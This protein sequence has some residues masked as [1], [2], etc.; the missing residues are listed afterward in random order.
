MAGVL[1]SY[2]A[3]WRSW[4]R[5]DRAW[6]QLPDGQYLLIYRVQNFGAAETDIEIETDV[7]FVQCPTPD[8]CVETVTHHLS[9]LFGVA[10]RSARRGI[11]PVDLSRLTLPG[12]H[13]EI[14]MHLSFPD[15]LDANNRKVF[16]FLTVAPTFL[17]YIVFD[18]DQ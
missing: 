2:P 3:Q 13:Y 7:K 11:L 9:K 15:D 17:P 14:D 1:E 5:V 8:T 4:G 16:K 10:P 6:E 12:E 18:L